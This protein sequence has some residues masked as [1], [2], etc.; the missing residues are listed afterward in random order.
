MKK[1]EDSPYPE[2]WRLPFFLL[3]VALI[4]LF[5]AYALQVSEFS[6]IALWRGLPNLW[7]ILLSFLTPEISREWMSTA[8]KGLWETVMMAIL[9]TTLGVILTFPLSFLAARN[10]V[11]DSLISRSIYGLIRGIFNLCRTLDAMVLAIL[12]VVAVGIGPFPGVLALVV[13]S[14]GMLGKLFSEAIE[15]VDPGVVEAVTATGASPVQKISF[16]ILPQVF[17]SFVGFILFRLDANVRMSTVLG[18]VGAGGIGYLLK[19]S[20]DVL[21]YR[22][23][24]TLLW[25]IGIVVTLFDFFS[26]WARSRLS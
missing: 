25:E 24:A 9:G 23:A 15:Q 7:K 12:F 14:V 2:S 18:L 4:I 8:L 1:I 6:L 5:Y 19:Q 21:A 22:Q 20:I 26:A 16:G 10:L 11:G 3:L 13:H 17:P